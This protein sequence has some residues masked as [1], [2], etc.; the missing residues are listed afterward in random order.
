MCL[1]EAHHVLRP[2]GLLWGAG[3]SH[4]A[5]LFDSLAHGLFD[6]PDFAPILARD[7]AEGQHRNTSGNLT[8]F[9]DAF[10]HRPGELSRDFLSAGFQVVAV[11]AIEGGR[12]GWRVIS[13][14]CGRIQFSMSA[15]WY[16]CAKWNVS[17][18][19]W[20]SALTSWR[21]DGSE[22]QKG[23]PES[24]APGINI[25]CATCLFNEDLRLKCAIHEPEL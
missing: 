8:Y 16:R 11:V 18:Q 12:D 9:T 25:H 7:L 19:C 20:A 21:S 6:D 1:R 2:G 22:K 24:A 10:L 15:C 17:H 5:P 4:F 3:I 13:T 23:R 14:A